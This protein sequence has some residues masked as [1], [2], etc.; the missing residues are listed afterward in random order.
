M[1]QSIVLKAVWASLVRQEKGQGLPFQGGERGPGFSCEAA[2]RDPA[3]IRGRPL[4]GSSRDSFRIVVLSKRLIC[5]YL[6]TGLDRKTNFAS[7]IAG[8]A[9]GLAKLLTFCFSIRKPDIFK[10][11]S[12]FWANVQKIGSQT[13]VGALGTCTRGGFAAPIQVPTGSWNE[14]TASTETAASPRPV[15]HLAVSPH[16]YGP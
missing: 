15:N 4:A 13:S 2:I 5:W 16:R 1:T 6:F 9:A 7:I 3:S 14:P 8:S 12:H 10:N 11:R